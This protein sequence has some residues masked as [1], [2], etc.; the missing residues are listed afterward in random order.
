[1]TA[2]ATLLA[3][4]KVIVPFGFTVTMPSAG[5]TG[6]APVTDN[7]LPSA[8]ESFAS[9]LTVTGRLI[10]VVAMSAVAL[11]ASFTEVTPSVRVAPVVAV[12][13]LTV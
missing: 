2:P 11:G 8:S 12:P 3:G 7:G 1:M 13:S 10:G 5:S 6:L 4:V 9:T